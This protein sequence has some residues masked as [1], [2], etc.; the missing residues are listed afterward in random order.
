[1]SRTRSC[2]FSVL[3]PIASPALQYI[4]SIICKLFGCLLLINLI[5]VYSKFHQMLLIGTLI[6]TLIGI[7]SLTILTYSLFTTAQLK[8]FRAVCCYYSVIR[9]I[10]WRKIFN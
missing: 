9:S 1:M 2:I 8:F 6:G 5:Y 10:F 7:K 3:L 4:I